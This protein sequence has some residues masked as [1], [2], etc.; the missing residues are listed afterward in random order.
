MISQPAPEVFVLLYVGAG[1][2]SGFLLF[3]VE[4]VWGKQS[5]RVV[6]VVVEAFKR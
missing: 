6:L 2:K 4:G 5:N 1:K 3:R